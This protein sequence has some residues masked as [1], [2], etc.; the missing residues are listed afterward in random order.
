VEE[1]LR[2]ILEELRHQGTP[3]WVEVLRSVVPIVSGGLVAAIGFFAVHQQNKTHR[4][5]LKETT[6]AQAELHRTERLTAW[7]HERYGELSAAFG[8]FHG[9]VRSMNRALNMAGQDQAAQD[10]LLAALNRFIQVDLNSRI[11]VAS[12][13][14]ADK[15]VA[16]RAHKLADEY[17]VA[18]GQLVGMAAV[19]RLPDDEKRLGE[20]FDRLKK[21]LDQSSDMRYEL[22]RRI[23]K[24]IS[25][26]D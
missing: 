18:S 16:E 14:V 19:A 20:E 2:Q 3:W 15:D 22:N 6:A 24:L 8:E 7:R 4:E 11:L 5:T 23:E 10:R 1:L 26:G 12:V 17:Y 9:A 25:E 21:R 13:Q